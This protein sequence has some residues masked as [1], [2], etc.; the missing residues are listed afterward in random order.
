MSTD[1]DWKK[2]GEQDP[3][4]GVLT[5]EKFRKTAIAQNQAEFFETG[6]ET[7]NRYLTAYQEVFGPVS[8]DSALDFGCGVGRLSLALARRFDRVVG[9]DIAPGMLS[10]AQ[11]NAALLGVTNASFETADDALSN[12]PGQFGFVNCYIVLQ[13]IPTARGMEIIRQL[14]AKIKPGGGCLIHICVRGPL[15][16]IGSLK[17]KLFTGTTLGRAYSNWRNGRP[18]SALVMQMNEYPLERVLALFHAAGMNKT[19]SMFEDHGAGCH[20][21]SILA[22][23]TANER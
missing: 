7:V 15:S 5:H 11:K 19:V 4:F 18:L 1:A 16:D 3:Y 2:W 23:K 17:Y 22:K 21:V 10:E 6:E 20:T 14:V 12:A 13:H 9:L 8:G